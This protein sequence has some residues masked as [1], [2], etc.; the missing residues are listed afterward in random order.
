[1]KYILLL[2]FI[3]T[4]TFCLDYRKPTKTQKK[5]FAKRLGEDAT[6]KLLESLRKYHRTH[7]KATLLDYILDKRPDLKDVADVCLLNIRRRRLD[8]KN[9]NPGMKEIDQAI[10]YYMD[11]LGRDSKVRNELSK[12]LKENKNLAI[13]TCKS[14]LQDKELCKLI[15]E[16]MQK[17]FNEDN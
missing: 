12:G 11:S 6:Q 3:F 13:H 17:N 15:I 1:M 2:L 9:K 5:C 4:F 16:S 7:G 8:K 10:K 14:Y